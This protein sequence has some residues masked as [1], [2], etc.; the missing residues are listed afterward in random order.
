M[1]FRTTGP[2]AE[3]DP[4]KH[5]LCLLQGLEVASREGWRELIASIEV[6]KL[7]W[8]DLLS[9]EDRLKPCLTLGVNGYTFDGISIVQSDL[10]QPTT[11]LTNCSRKHLSAI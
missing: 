8:L 9:N 6:P 5:S 11:V 7:F 1:Q 4:D 3:T 10:S 2:K